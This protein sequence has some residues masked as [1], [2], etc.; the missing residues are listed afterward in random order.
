MRKLKEI[1]EN[2]TAT[3]TFFV[4]FTKRFFTKAPG[5]IFAQ[6]EKTVTDKL[7]ASL[8]LKY[9]RSTK[10]NLVEFQN[11][12]SCLSHRFMERIHSISLSLSSLF[13]STH[14]HI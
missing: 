9:G 5:E 6:F 3:V 2:S 8:Q 10:R 11:L 7:Q 4:Y 13:Y 12:L 14:S 1:Y